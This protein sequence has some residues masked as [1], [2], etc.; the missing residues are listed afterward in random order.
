[1]LTRLL[2]CLFASLTLSACA[3]Q[4]PL[5][6][7][8]IAPPAHWST[9]S[10]AELETTDWTAWQS[11]QL[12]TLQQQALSANL[13]IASSIA[14]LRQADAQLQQSGASLLPQLSAGL[15][16]N[17]SDSERTDSDG[18]SSRNSYSGNLN[19]SYEVDLWGRL[20]AERDASRASLLA[21]EFDHA[22]LLLTIEA[23]VASTW[24]QRL[25]TR[26]RL[27]LAEDSLANAQRVLELVENR[28][29]LGAIDSL[30]VSQQRTLVAQL[31]AGLPTLRQQYRQQSN[32][33]ALLIGQG[34]DAELPESAPALLADLQV[35]EIAPGL[36]AS[37]L[38]RRPDIRASEARL[39]AANADLTAARAALY[40]SIQLTGQYGAQSLALSSLVNNPVTAWNLAAGLS[41]PI[42]QGGRLRARVAQTRARQDELLID[43]QRTLL[44]AFID[45]DNA[46]SNVDQTRQRAAYLAATEAEASRALELAEIR[47]RSG[48]IDLQTL[49]DTQRTWYSSQ[50]NLAQ[51]RAAQLLASVDLFRAL[52]GGWQAGAVSYPTD[53]D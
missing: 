24:F 5:P 14:R 12:Q 4:T 20:R 25:E 50:D 17:R 1:M 31:Q 52:G 26:R 30:E 38:Q 22:S 16:A 15:G 10:S 29:R 9:E 39:Q 7:Q 11:A 37:L 23:S 32:A 28:Y 43:Y 33:L 45:V 41:Q 6:E 44:T 19:A 49:L 3:L 35:P 36:P 34:P 47:Y 40:P 13:D 46:L 27:Q 2:A 48:A 21:S 51:V 42:F 18:N 8:P 53:N